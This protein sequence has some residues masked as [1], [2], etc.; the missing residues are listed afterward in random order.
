WGAHPGGE[1]RRALLRQWLALTAGALAVFLLLGASQA[2]WLAAD[3]SNHT[4]HSPETVA[5]GLEKWVEHTPFLYVNRNDWLGAWLPDHAP[6]GL[7]LDP[8][9]PL[10][11]PRRYLGL[12][13]LALC[14]VGWGLARSDFGLRRWFQTFLLL[15]TFQYWMSIG[16]QT[17]VWQMARR[18]HW[19]GGGGGGGGGGA[20]GR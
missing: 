15:F 13:A 7:Q 6:P 1:R 12:V 5:Q 14:V 18:L 4:L 16:P 19:P 8:G 3:L 17:L 10:F 2:A 9:L 11:N 20:A